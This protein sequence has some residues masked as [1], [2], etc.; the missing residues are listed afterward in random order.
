M[1]GFFCAYCFRVVNWPAF[2]NLLL[3]SGEAMAL[4]A[5]SSMAR[6]IFEARPSPRNSAVS[7]ITLRVAV[8]LFLWIWQALIVLIIVTALY[9][10]GY[11]S[12]IK[13]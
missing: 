3:V 4:L 12:C 10:H 2:V 5:L 9:W 8:S 6:E 11:E 7:N 13:A 1:D